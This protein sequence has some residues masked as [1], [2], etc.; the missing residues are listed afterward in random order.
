M[1]RIAQNTIAKSIWGLNP[2]NQSIWLGH[3]R[4]WW[5]LIIQ[6]PSYV[7]FDHFPC[8]FAYPILSCARRRLYCALRR[9]HCALRRVHCALR[10]L[11]CALARLHCAPARKMCTRKMC[12]KKAQKIFCRV[13][14]FLQGPFFER[15]MSK[16]IL[17]C[18]NFPA[19]AFFLEKKA[20]S[21]KLWYRITSNVSKIDKNRQKV[22]W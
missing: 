3:V 9:L 2:N 16:H 18:V 4:S 8:I 1:G 17:P 7:R 21:V 11:H 22:I 20:F 6:K 10:R 15:K 5:I 19:G 13:W 14:I 12:T